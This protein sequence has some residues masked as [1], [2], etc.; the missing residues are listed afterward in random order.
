MQSSQKSGKYSSTKIFSL[1]IILFFNF[2]F[3]DP[4]K[5]LN[6]DFLLDKNVKPQS[7]NKIKSKKKSK[8]KAF[9]DVLKDFQKIDGLFTLYWNKKTNQ[10]YVSILPNQL[11]HIYLAGLTRQSGDG[12]YLDG[13]SMLNEYPFMFRKVGKRIQ[14]LNANVKFRADEDSPFRRAVERHTSHS[15]LSSTETASAPHPETGAVLADIGK[16]FIYDIEEITRRSQGVYSFDKKD[17]Y[18][19]EIKSFPIIQKL[20]LPSISKVKRESI[21]ILFPVLPAC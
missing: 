19:T 9:Q 1:F 7:A 5:D 10:A 8:E 17:S 6:I 15:I 2:T 3:A 16:L 20:K 13:S 4:F 14:F 21:F 11:D 12:Y 18:F